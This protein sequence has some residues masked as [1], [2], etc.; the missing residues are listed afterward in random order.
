MKCATEVPVSE[1]TSVAVPMVVPPSLKVTVPEGAVAGV[2]VL[3]LTCTV[4]VKV[5]TSPK[6]E[7]GL[8][9]VVVVVVAALFTVWLTVL[10]FTL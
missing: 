7:V 5:T 10:L 8:E 3:G 9:L 1:V 6:V 2:S 4:A